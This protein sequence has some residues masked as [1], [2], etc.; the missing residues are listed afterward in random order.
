MSLFSDYISFPVRTLS[1]GYSID[2]G[3]E[4]LFCIIREI[5]FDDMVES[6]IKKKEQYSTQSSDG[7]LNTTLSVS[8]D[9]LLPELAKTDGHVTP[10][11]Q[12]IDIPG[13]VSVL[14]LRHCSVLLGHVNQPK[15]NEV[16]LA[17]Q[18]F[19][20]LKQLIGEL[21]GKHLNKDISEIPDVW[22]VDVL[23]MSNPIY[24][25]LDFTEQPQNGGLFCRVNYR[26]GRRDP[27]ELT[28]TGKAKDGEVTETIVW[29]LDGGAFLYRTNLPSYHSLD[30]VVKDKEGRVVDQYLDMHFIRNISVD[31]KVL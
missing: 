17:F 10:L 1:I 18:E 15:R 12:N 6:V 4:K 2:G 27:L 25:S 22:G 16:E 9:E 21:S 7:R 23:M 13:L 30:I 5:L 19:P 11:F 3:E 24:R 26:R 8:Y 20:M 28:V 14:P 29:T 31:V